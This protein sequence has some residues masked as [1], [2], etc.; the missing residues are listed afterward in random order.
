M[1]TEMPF[2]TSFS[3][4]GATAILQEGKVLGEGAC[5]WKIA[6]V[7]WVSGFTSNMQA[8]TNMAVHWETC[9]YQ[10][11]GV[12]SPAI[13]QFSHSLQWWRHCHTSGLGHCIPAV[14]KTCSQSFNLVLLEAIQCNLDQYCISVYKLPKKMA[15]GHRNLRKTLEKK[16]TCWGLWRTL[17]DR[18][19]VD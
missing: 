7:N 16:D 4:D 9:I 10:Q 11:F 1:N 18:S 15:R 13:A 12:K 19:C 8:M 5:V 17:R 14:N 2:T 3:C 6:C